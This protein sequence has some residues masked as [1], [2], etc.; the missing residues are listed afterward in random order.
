MKG[1]I[2]VINYKELSFALA[3]IILFVVFCT[4]M[5]SNIN[6]KQEPAREASV[7]EIDINSF[8]NAEIELT[9]KST[10][11]GLRLKYTAL[12]NGTE[13]EIYRKVDGEKGFTIIETTQKTK[14]TDNTVITGKIYIY[15][16]RAVLKQKEG[17]ITTAFSNKV[18]RKYVWF[19]KNKKMVAL[20][21]DDGPGRYTD[22]ILKCFDK[23]DAHAT[24][25][26]VGSEIKK[27]KSTVKKAD[28]I[29]CEIGSHTFD[30]CDL[31]SLSKNEIKNQI[32]KTDKCLKAIIGHKATLIRPPYGFVNSYVKQVVKK[33]IVT[34]NVDTRDWE[35]LSSSKTYK[36]VMKSVE[37]GDI[38]LMHDIHK[39]TKNAVLKII[40]KLKKKG[41]QIVT[42]S[43]LAEYKGT[44][45][46]NG[47]VYTE[48]N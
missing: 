42:V 27:Y 2:K 31:T 17:V 21:F 30:H 22:S 41:Y 38:I 4:T 5:I 26:V 9:L 45:L 7:T 36:N 16:V 18:K 25:F 13:Y 8:I 33:P 3:W 6:T 28:L 48:I 35:T 34:W 20:T 43:E 24:F 39:S 32:K 14:F 12:P 23:Y 1:F 10:E 44:K 19:D 11:K 37:D 47:N 40:P 29:G 15:K 46:K